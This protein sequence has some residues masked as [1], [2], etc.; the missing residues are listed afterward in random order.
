MTREEELI[1]QGWE[2]QSTNDEPRLSELVETYKEI[3]FEIHLEPF[4]PDEE[5]GCTECMKISPDIY[6]TIYIK[7]KSPEDQN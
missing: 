2:K 4:N 6:K 7:K 1:S 5:P 3:G